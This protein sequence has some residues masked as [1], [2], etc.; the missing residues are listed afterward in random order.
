M[1]LK[2]L[3]IKLRGNRRSIGVVT[4]KNRVL[5]PVAQLFIAQARSLAKAMAQDS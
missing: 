5:S 4:L 1:S 3:P 2:V